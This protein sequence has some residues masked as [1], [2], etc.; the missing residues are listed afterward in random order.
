MLKAAGGRNL[1]KARRGTISI[2]FALISPSLILVVIGVLDITRAL[3]L[4]QQVYNTAHT[5]PLSASSIAVQPD[6]TTSLTVDQVQQGL[7]AI[8]AEVP[9]IRS[10]TE[11]GIRSVTMSSITFVQAVPACVPSATVACAS[12]PFV[13][14]SVAYQGG[15]A[16]GF[17]NVVRA[18]GALKQTAASA[19]AA[20][21]LT[22]LRTA[23]ISNPDPILVVDVHYRYTP[24][25]FNFLTGSVDL[26][27]SGYWPVRV[28]PNTI[29]AQQYTR[30]DIANKAGGA[31]KCAGFS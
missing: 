28:A 19:G 18:C 4:Y 12:T 7:S 3:I 24:M 25:F 6:L 27:A 26:W 13:A 16:S 21:D 2:E 14:W 5:I 31:G 30:Y 9:W 22:S 8:Y 17:S 15:N 20:G 11:T 23:G 29:L 10:G 1:A